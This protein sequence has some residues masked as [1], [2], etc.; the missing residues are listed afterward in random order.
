MS[1]YKI[2]ILLVFNREC[3]NFCLANHA[4]VPHLLRGQPHLLECY[5]R[6]CLI[7]TH[8]CTSS[9]RVISFFYPSVWIVH[10][11]QCF[12]YC[13]PCVRTD[14]GKGGGQPN[15][16]RLGRERKGPKN[17]QICANILYGWPPPRRWRIGLTIWTN[18][19]FTILSEK[20]RSMVVHR[21]TQRVTPISHTKKYPDL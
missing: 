15:V 12:K 8:V 5:Y 2:L 16:D 1:V 21:A 3:I 13:Q 9:I 17:S 14:K 4:C 10:K 18:S 19:K 20:A 7:G 6:N 11:L